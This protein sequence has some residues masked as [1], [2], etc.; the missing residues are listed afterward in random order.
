VI[1]LPAYDGSDERDLRSHIRLM[2]AVYANDEKSIEGLLA[3]HDN[4]HNGTPAGRPI[5]HEHNANIR[6]LD[7]V[8]EW[9]W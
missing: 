3:C 4:E 1:V 7:E 2:H 5:R 6:T 9:Q 8:E